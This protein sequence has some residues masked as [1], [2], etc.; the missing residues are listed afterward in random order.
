[1]N[2]T[3]DFHILSPVKRDD[4]L[5]IIRWQSN[6]ALRNATMGFRFPISQ[7]QCDL[8]YEAKIINGAPDTAIFAIR[9]DTEILGI[10]Q[11]HAIDHTHQRAMLGVF[12]GASESRGQSLGKRAV[13]E[14][15]MFGFRDLNLHRIYL[16]VTANNSAAIKTYKACGFE[17]EGTLAR[18]YFA[19]GQ[20]ENVELYAKLRNMLH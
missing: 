17:L 15:L 14:L 13:E 20:W 2:A 3:Q 16:E 6:R 18:H 12:I 8:W 11:L 7:E 1:M 4:L 5:S 19:N 10:A 9:V